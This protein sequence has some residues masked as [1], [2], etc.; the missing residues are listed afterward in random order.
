VSEEESLVDQIAAFLERLQSLLDRTKDATI[1]AADF[2]A[3]AIQN[4]FPKYVNQFDQGKIQTSL[5]RLRP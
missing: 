2:C 5:K 1:E 3:Q 4:M